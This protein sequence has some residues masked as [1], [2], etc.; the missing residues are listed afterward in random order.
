MKTQFVQ[1][2]FRGLYT[3]R[4]ANSIPRGFAAHTINS[5]LS[6]SSQVSQ[7][8]GYSVFGHSDNVTDE[9]TSMF[10]YQR[11]LGFESMLQVRDNT[12]YAFLELLIPDDNRNSE[13]GEWLQLKADYATG[14][15]ISFA[16]YNDTGTDNLLMSNGS[17]YF[18]R[19]SGAV[20]KLAT[21]TVGSDA[22]ISVSKLTGDSKT[23]ATDGFGSSGTLVVMSD[24][25]VRTTITYTGKTAS[26]FTG[27]TGTPAM[28][29][30]AGIAEA[31]DISSYTSIAKF[32]CILTAQ[33]RVWGT[34]K[35]AA[36]T[37]LEYSEVG[38]FT[39]WTTGTNPDDPGNADFP[40]GGNNIALGSIDDWI[41][42]FKENKV[43]G[44]SFQYPDSTTRVPIRKQISDVGIASLNALALVGDDY[45]YVSPE[46]EIRRLSR[47]QTENL[48]QT[49]DLANMIR[50][51][52]K[53][54]VFTESSIGYWKKER[55]LLIAAKKDSDSSANDRVITIQF[56]ED[57]K[58]NAIYNLGILDWWVG[59]W[60]VFGKQL[61]HGGSADSQCYKS[62]DGY[63]KNGTPVLWEYMTK[64]E[65]FGDEF[66]KKQ[67]DGIWIKGKIGAGTTLDIKTYY[68]ENGRTQ[69][70]EGGRYQI[71]YV[72]E[73]DGDI[74]DID[75]GIIVTGISN[76][77]GQNALGSEPL[78]GTI[79]DIDDLDYFACFM[80]YP[81]NANPNNIQ[82]LF[83][84]FGQ[85]QRAVIYAYGFGKIEDANLTNYPIK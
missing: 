14:Y 36:G 79:D 52:I 44:Y 1:T 84:T 10:T 51:S 6:S 12:S 85:G 69:T 37:L 22:T 15:V 31:V 34:G 57:E 7:M 73:D 80:P 67:I 24:A 56:S 72:A 49:E 8:K 30:N 27:C 42:I 29:V 45:I 61:Y 20:C 16:P 66:M 70:F 77:L 47:V 62:F 63:D 81:I 53:D 46:G 17:D 64:I 23:N 21:A 71:K 28:S 40:E 75:N 18:S 82:I 50:P 54:F 76:P 25:G 39:N 2:E 9:I 55:I 5:D 3:L 11:G 41:I 74:D 33:G 13:D 19:W 59:D 60:T 26:T 65:N 68:D 78:G 48:F 4:R 38:D 58:Q 35:T 32:K 83:T 43:W